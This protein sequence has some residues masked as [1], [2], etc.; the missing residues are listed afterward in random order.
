[1]IGYVVTAIAMAEI[2]CG[3]AQLPDFIDLPAG[4]GVIAT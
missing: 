3:A 1:M 2:A 4:G